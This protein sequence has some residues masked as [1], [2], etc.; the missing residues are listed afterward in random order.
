MATLKKGFDPMGKKSAWI[1]RQTWKVNHES[2][3]NSSL[4]N[5]NYS[6]CGLHKYII[7]QIST[8]K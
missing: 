4:L 3:D 6:I 2:V 7:F 5:C 1:E 8:A